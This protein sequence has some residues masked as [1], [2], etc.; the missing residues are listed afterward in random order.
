MKITGPNGRVV[1]VNEENR[2]MVSAVA[3]S[4]D[5][6]LNSE[7]RY[8]SA[9]FEDTTLAAD[10]YF[11]YFK[12]TG[13]KDLN[14]TDVRVSSSVSLNTMYYEH[15]SGVAAGTTDVTVTSRNLGSPKEVTGLVQSGA[16]ITGLTN[17]GELFFQK[18]DV[19][20]RG[21]HL[22]SSSNV[23]IPQGQ[24]IAFRS[25]LAATIECIVSI[26]EAE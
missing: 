23:I 1:L 10:E 4:E 21:Y 8:W 13:L 16:G 14:L 20:A 7:E 19:A 9:Y 24:A 12:N 17:I 15:V 5:K 25:A 2:L 22:K 6:H 11:F 26:S 3:L 18:C